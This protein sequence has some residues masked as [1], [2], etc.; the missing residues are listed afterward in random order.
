MFPDH[1]EDDS[2]WPD[3]DGNG[4]FEP[5]EPSRWRRG[6][7]VIIASVTALAIAAVPVYNLVQAGDRPVADNGLEVC[8]FDYCVI[9]DMVTAAGLGDT[10]SRLAVTFLN[11]TEAEVFAADLQAHL[12]RE[13]AGFEMVNDLD[14]DISGEYSPDSNTIRIERPAR[15]W[16]VLHEVAHVGTDGHEEDFRETLLDLAAWVEATTG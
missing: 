8:G 7:L 15:A 13:P 2:H 1:D 11:D 9:Q 14:G 6:A 12:G 16:I 5:I 4:D 10:M 3:A